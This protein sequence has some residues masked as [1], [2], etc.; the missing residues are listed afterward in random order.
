MM[1][2]VRIFFILCSVFISGGINTLHAQSTTGPSGPPQA[3]APAAKASASPETPLAKADQFYRT[4]RL[5][6][7]KEEY[8]AILKTE[9]G[10]A[11]AYVG[12][13]RVYLREKR[14]DEAYKAAQKAIELAP[15][16]DA[17]HVAMGEAYFRQG[18][19][20]EAE[21]EFAALV[22]RNSPDPRAHLGLYKVYKAS[23]YYKH[24]KMAID[25]AY[26]LDP[27]DPDI[28]RA[29]M[30]TLDVKDQM[31]ALLAYLA[32][33]ANEDPEERTNLDHRLTVLQDDEAQSRHGCHL[34]NK[35]NAMV[36]NLERLAY[37]ANNVRGYGLHVVLN[38]VSSKLLLDT[39]AGGI[40]IDR[41]IAEKAG[42][43]PVVHTEVKGIGDKGAAAGYMGYAESIK[44][45]DLEFQDCLVEVID[46]KSVI[47]DDGLIGGDVFSSFLV[48]IDFPDAKF[49]LSQLP[50]LP[51]EPAP[52]ASLQSRSIGITYLHDRYVAPEMKEF[53]PVFRFGSH[54]LIDTKVNDLPPKLFM[55]DTG[56]F[57]NT[58]SPSAAREVTSVSSYSQLQVKGISGEVK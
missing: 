2:S 16:L 58:I 40:L 29:W 19:L 12:L 42:I 31:K 51:N 32:G 21:S 17:A 48:D 28:R 57:A 41:K 46:Q 9:P 53:S 54:L 52:I 20:H 13:A 15:A 14:P 55:I 39:G 1:K 50:S 33:K 22:R 25:R 49:K 47:G 34:T 37:D 35:L 10:S 11:L 43:Q 4:G 23:S 36:T 5:D 18:K 7:A 44:I 38:G 24:A 26:A 6:T 3:T 27:A 8:T 45:G 56:A 30:E